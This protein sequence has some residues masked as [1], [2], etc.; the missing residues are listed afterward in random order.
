MSRNGKNLTIYCH[1][2][3]LVLA[4]I[5]ASLIAR[6]NISLIDQEIALR[7]TAD[8]LSYNKQRHLNDEIAAG[9]VLRH[10][11]VTVNPQV[12]ALANVQEK[13]LTLTLFN[14]ANFLTDTISG[15]RHSNMEMT[16]QAN[17]KTEPGS[18]VLNVHNG[19]LNGVIRTASALYRIEPAAEG[20][21]LIKEIAMSALE[22]E[23]DALIVDRL[24]K[25][26]IETTRAGQSANDSSIIDIMVVYTPAAA[27]SATDIDSEIRL[28]ISEL[29]MTFALSGIRHRARL[30][31]SSEVN[32]TESGD[33]NTDLDRI[34]EYGDGHMDVVH[35]MRDVFGA[36]VVSLWTTNGGNG[37]G[38]VMQNPDPSFESL[39][40]HAIRW[41]NAVNNFTFA[42]ELGHNLGAAHD[43]EN[44]VIAGS[45]SYA[46]GYQDPAGSWRTIMAYSDGCSC[47]RI[48]YWSNPEKLH[49]GDG[50]WMGIDGGDSLGADNRQVLN[51]NGSIVAAFRSGATIPFMAVSPEDARM[52][53]IAGSKSLTVE[54]I[55]AGSM[56]WS[57]TVTSGGEW[58]TIS[59]GASGADS[60]SIVLNY[61]ENTLLVSRTAAV[62]ISAPGVANSPQTIYLTQQGVI[63]YATLPYTN[64]FESGIWENCWRTDSDHP[65]GDIAIDGEINPFNGN[66]SLKMAASAIG[67]MV[68]N[69]AR[70]H[71]NLAGEKNV[72]LEFQWLHSNEETH[73]KDGVFF[74]DDAGESFRL[75]QDFQSLSYPANSWIHFSLNVDSLAMVH[76]LTLSEHF[77]VKFQ[78]YDNFPFGSDGFAIDDIAVFSRAIEVDARVW[79]SGAY[80][81]VGDS[82][83]TTLAAKSVLPLNQPYNDISWGYNGN[84]AVS[85]MPGDI[86]DWVL[87]ELRHSPAPESIVTRR[88]GLLS[89][90]GRVVDVDGE[91][92]ICFN[93]DADNYYLVVYHYNHLP[94]M[95]LSPLILSAD[96][97]AIAD[98]SSS[99]A[100]A[101]GTNAL[102]FLEAGVYGMITGDANSDGIVNVDDR[103][104]VWRSENG[105]PWEYFN[106]AD[107][108]LDG[109]VDAIDINI[110]WRSA[111]GMQRQ[112]P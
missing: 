80:Q 73:L 100:N 36:D 62:S 15:K 64:G 49:P 97:I 31:Y 37:A 96:T 68:T 60:G 103:E 106:N 111:I 110:H 13:T 6:E 112:V 10:R 74:S 92:P 32:Y 79:L 58:L 25:G 95:S 61:P 54:N 65:N 26:A 93:A 86:V 87:L 88:A 71:L 16:L 82:M 20:V 12:A 39:A 102:K 78:Q 104:G 77:V 42:H 44:A 56:N 85:E 72:T 89:K 34:K 91:S 52:A 47:S 63:D 66:Y 84:E 101:Y 35:V 3:F 53:H 48:S 23:C 28:A 11:F 43:R 51:Q 22:G 1:R 46:H 2:L 76:G 18:L 5:S 19:T 108:N 107:F 98:L 40:F 70:L 7:K 55:G 59:A 41:D 24:T 8:I 109:G 4:F 33:L 27:L 57:A 38:Y 105:I 69:D 81:A 45:A 14:D 83:S 29:N 67:P 99:A 94:V 90:D 75:V 30:V 50:S 9:K 17:L 21:Y